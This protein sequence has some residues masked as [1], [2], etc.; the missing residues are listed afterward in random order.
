[1]SIS[2]SPLFSSHLHPSLIKLLQ[3]RAFGAQDFFAATNTKILDHSQL[4]Y[5]ERPRS[6]LTS[7]SSWR[8]DPL[9]S[10]LV[11]QTIASRV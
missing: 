1:M 3:I 2:S 11:V 4:P 5:R 10:P 7:R 8:R 6:R 9:T